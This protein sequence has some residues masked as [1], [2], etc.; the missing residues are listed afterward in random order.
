MQIKLSKQQ[1]RDVHTA[2]QT[3]KLRYINARRQNE[4]SEHPDEK[5]LKGIT[6]TIGR[7]HKLMVKFN[8]LA[9]PKK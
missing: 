7:I 6:L 1:V 2:L 3:A 5:W 9:F 8:K 4:L